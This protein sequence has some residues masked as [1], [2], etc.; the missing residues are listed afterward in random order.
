MSLNPGFLSDGD[1]V[2]FSGEVSRK[3]KDIRKGKVEFYDGYHIANRDPLWQ[4]AKLVKHGLPDLTCFGALNENGFYIINGFPY[5]PC[6]LLRILR[7]D[8]ARLE[9]AGVGKEEEE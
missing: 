7:K 5:S 1:E 2:I 3:V 9:E 8:V 6:T 4:L